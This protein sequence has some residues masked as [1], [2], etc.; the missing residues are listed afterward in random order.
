MV[1]IAVA[2]V[3]LAVGRVIPIIV[4]VVVLTLSTVM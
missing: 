4:V 3:V 1:I 2:T